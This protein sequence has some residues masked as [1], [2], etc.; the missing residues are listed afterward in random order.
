MIPVKPSKIVCIGR[1]YLAHARELGNEL[2]PEVWDRYVPLRDE[3]RSFVAKVNRAVREGNALIR[4]YNAKV[5]S[6][7]ALRKGC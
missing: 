6:Y 5:R 2:P 7:R 3:Y 4:V 1:N